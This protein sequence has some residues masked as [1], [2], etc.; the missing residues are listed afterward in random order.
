MTAAVGSLDAASDS[1]LAPTRR[2]G[3]S[4]H[5]I[6]FTGER[7][8]HVRDVFRPSLLQFLRGVKSPTFGL[9]YRP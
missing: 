9:D 6:I 4:F 5:T 2:L 1:P 7:Y 8:T 3:Q